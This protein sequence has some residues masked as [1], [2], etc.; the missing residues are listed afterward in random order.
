MTIKIQTLC[1]ATI[2][3]GG[4]AFA[5]QSSKRTSRQDGAMPAVAEPEIHIYRADKLAGMEIMGGGDVP[6]G[7]LDA[8]IVDSASG[9]L[10]YAVISKGGLLG[11]GESRRLV[12]WIALYFSPK[13]KPS[14]REFEASR[15]APCRPVKAH[16]PMAHS[17]GMVVW[18][19]RLVVIPPHM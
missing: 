14:K 3:L 18:P 13:T 6:I 4:F 16:S 7:K 10:A 19:C 8:L 12:P 5:L 17:P 2:A 15:F 11:V 1:I 9:Q